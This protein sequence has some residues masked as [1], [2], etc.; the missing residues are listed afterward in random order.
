MNADSLECAD[1][2]EQG[3]ASFPHGA[4]S[5]ASGSLLADIGV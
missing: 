4:K 1:A 5:R 3:A 2:K